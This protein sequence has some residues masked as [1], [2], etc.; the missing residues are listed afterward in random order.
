MTT[1]QTDWQQL[2]WAGIKLLAPSDWYV[3]QLRVTQN[4]SYIRMEDDDMV[5]FELSCATVSPIQQINLREHAEAILSKMAKEAK[6]RG[7]EFSQSV[8]TKLVGRHQVKGRDVL[9]FSWAGRYIGEGMLWWCG[10]CGKVLVAHVIGVKGERLKELA[11]KLFTSI[12]DHSEDEWHS[13]KLFGLDLKVHS[14]MRLCGHKVEAGFVRFQFKR[15]DEDSL[16]V[17]RWSTADLML[18]GTTLDKLAAQVLKEHLKKF[19]ISYRHVQFGSSSHEGIELYGKAKMPLKTFQLF[20]RQ[21]TKRSLMPKLRGLMW[22]CD[23]TN[24]LFLVLAITASEGMSEF[25]HVINSFKC[26]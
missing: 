10:K 2:A 4:E 7:E 1:S 13:W 18:K 14:S 24:R 12:S 21:L 20:L 9:T 8:D 19:E 26:H 6:K 23:N 11:K 15:G 16:E 22:K 5:R 3:T 25:E 17:A